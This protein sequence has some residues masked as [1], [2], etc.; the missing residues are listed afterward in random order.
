MNRDI[1]C[2]TCIDLAQQRALAKQN[3]FA[4]SPDNN[5]PALNRTKP[6]STDPKVDKPV[7]IV[8]TARTQQTFG[9][10]SDL[11]KLVSSLRI[12]NA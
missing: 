11:F 9:M 4:Y 7:K 2:F 10:T 1:L 3:T 5:S 12:Q 6:K 8:L